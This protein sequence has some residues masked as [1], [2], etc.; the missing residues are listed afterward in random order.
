MQMT[1]RTLGV[2]ATAAAA[3]CS[4]PAFAQG[5]KKTPLMIAPRGASGERPESTLLAFRQAI[6]EGA[7]FIEPDL[8]VTKDGHLV[9]RHEHEISQTTH[10]ASRPES[11]SRKTTKSVQGQSETG[12]FTEDFT[13]A[14]LK[15]LRC[16]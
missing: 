10:V 9:V 1:R 3:L 15:T 2:A 6:A 12:W 13:L 14:E 4:L 8:E 16:R 11:A 5:Y 7:D